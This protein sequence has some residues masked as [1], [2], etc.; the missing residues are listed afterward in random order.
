MKATTIDGQVM[1][2]NER[3]FTDID[4]VASLIGG[5]NQPYINA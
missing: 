3:Q 4:I 5:N 2:V 1:H